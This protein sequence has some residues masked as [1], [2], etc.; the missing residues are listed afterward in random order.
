MQYI[1]QG[2]NSMTNY[3]DKNHVVKEWLFFFCYS[4]MTVHRLKNLEVGASAQSLIVYCSVI[5]TVVCSACFYVETRTTPRE[6]S[7]H[8]H[9]NHYL[10]KY[11][12]GLPAAGS[13]GHFFTTEVPSS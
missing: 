8:S 2:F 12:T 6:G 9:I 3:H 5:V 1:G 7:R 10:R 4:S 13:D 11:Y